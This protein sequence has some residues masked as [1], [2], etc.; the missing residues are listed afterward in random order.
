LNDG[1]IR[2]RLSPQNKMIDGDHI[3]HIFE[4]IGRSLTS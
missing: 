2:Q 3:R 1:E 4:E